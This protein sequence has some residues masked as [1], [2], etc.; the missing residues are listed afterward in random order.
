LSHWLVRIGRERAEIN[1]A[2]LQDLLRLHYRYRF[3]PLGL[4]AQERSAFAED[5]Q[6][7][8]QAHASLR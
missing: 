6:R 1:V 3:D 4:S 5:V 8:L 7:W 2:Q